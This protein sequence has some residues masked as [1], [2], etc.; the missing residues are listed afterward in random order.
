MN[1][2]DSDSEEDFKKCK[3]VFSIGVESKL[4]LIPAIAGKTVTIIYSSSSINNANFQVD[5][6]GNN[7]WKPNGQASG[8][9]IGITSTYLQTYYALDIKSLQGS[10]LNTFYI[11][12]SI[13][14]NTY[15][16][17]D[18]YQ[19]DQCVAGS[20]KTYYFKPVYAKSIRIV[21]KEGTPNIKFEF[22]FSNT[23]ALTQTTQQQVDTY[24]AK[25]VL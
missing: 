7:G 1:F 6:E 23:S 9:F 22:Y 10:T 3:E 13:D 8:A 5:S 11:Q 15:Q 21:V 12:F 16:T 20:V 14:G 19:L 17:I 4:N 18:L 25:T 2:F 24:I